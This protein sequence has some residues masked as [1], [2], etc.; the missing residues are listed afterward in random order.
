MER[1]IHEQNLAH[2]EK[3]LAETT[4]PAKRQMILSLL[5]GEHAK[6]PGQPHNDL[7]PA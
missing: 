7:K 5:V 2:Y 1:F 4:D 3:V 6:E